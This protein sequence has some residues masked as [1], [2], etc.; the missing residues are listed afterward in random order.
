MIKQPLLFAI[1]GGALLVALG[2]FAWRG[3]FWLTA[4]ETD[5]VVSAIESKNT[6]C[7]SKRSKHACTRFT[8]VLTFH[9]HDGSSHRTTTSAGEER[10]YSQP[11]TDADRRV[12][13]HLPVLY[14]P[15]DPDDACHDSVWDVW[16]A[17]ILAMVVQVITLFGS[18]FEGK[19]RHY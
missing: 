14:S 12:G 8:A 17:P 9:A 10:G 3:V 4:Y 18:F 7:G 2:L 15:L 13:E 11:V 5:G 1:S 6:Q 19:K 16:G